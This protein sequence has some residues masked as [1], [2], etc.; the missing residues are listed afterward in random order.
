MLL[1]VLILHNFII[2]NPFYILGLNDFVYPEP[3]LLLQGLYMTKLKP[4]LV[5]SDSHIED[6]S[7]YHD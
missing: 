4:L 1:L 6:I 3:F 2:S 5:L 7:N